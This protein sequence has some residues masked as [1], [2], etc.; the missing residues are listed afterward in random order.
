MTLFLRWWE[1][2]SPRETTD[3]SVQFVV[4]T[5]LPNIPLGSPRFPGALVRQPWTVCHFLGF[6]VPVTAVWKNFSG[7]SHTPPPFHEIYPSAYGRNVP[8]DDTRHY[9]WIRYLAVAPSLWQYPTCI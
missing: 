5:T 9:N 2:L 3:N 4:W 7:I 8:R 1:E 6:Y